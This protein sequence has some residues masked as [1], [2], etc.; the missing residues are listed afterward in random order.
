MRSRSSISYSAVLL[1]GA[2]FRPLFGDLK[3]S[4]MSQSSWSHIAW[5]V[6]NLTFCVPI[7]TRAKLDLESPTSLQNSSRTASPRS[8][9]ILSA[10]RAANLQMRG[11]R[12]VISGIIARFPH[13]GNLSW[14]HRFWERTNLP[15]NV[16][17][18]R[19]PAPKPK[20]SEKMSGTPGF[21]KVLKT[22]LSWMNGFRCTTSTCGKPPVYLKKRS[23]VWRG[24]IRNDFHRVP[25][26]FTGMVTEIYTG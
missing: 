15:L 8:S 16:G 11:F 25:S 4:P 14:S 2:F 5:R 6:V 1:F 22:P 17:K 23:G 26:T 19:F 9:R 21:W 12:V 18:L 13:V 24:I 10:S 3:R 20:A 7:R